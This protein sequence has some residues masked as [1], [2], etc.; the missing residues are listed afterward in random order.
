M[1]AYDVMHEWDNATG[2]GPRSDEELDKV[3]PG[4]L[5][6]TDYAEWKAALEA[7]NIRAIIQGMKI[8][9]MPMEPLKPFDLDSGIETHERTYEPRA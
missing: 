6:E 2:K 1:N 3:I 7:S 5:G 9:G 8:W 4:L